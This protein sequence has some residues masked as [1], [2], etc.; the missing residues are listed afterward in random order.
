[1]LNYFNSLELWFVISTY[2]I[3]VSVLLRDVT[4]VSR[5]EQVNNEDSVTCQLRLVIYHVD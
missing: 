2:L 3:P 1:M 5:K 4:D